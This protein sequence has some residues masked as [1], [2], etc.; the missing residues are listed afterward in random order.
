L[1]KLVTKKV[2]KPVAP[3]SAREQQEDSYIAYLEGKL[4]VHKGKGK[5]VASEEDDGLDGMYVDIIRL[6]FSLMI[7]RITGRT[8][9]IRCT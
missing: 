1:E 7:C 3:K 8:R 2:V 9:G 6:I 4:G 5:K